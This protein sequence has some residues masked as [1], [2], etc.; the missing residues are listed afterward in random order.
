MQQQSVLAV[1]LGPEPTLLSRREVDALYETLQ[2]V[3]NALKSLRVEYIVTGGSLLGAIRQH[4]ILFCDDDIDIAIIET[5]SE[6]GT[7]TYDHVALNLQQELGSGYIYSKRPWEGGDKVRPTRMPSVFLDL[8]TIRRFDSLA[9]LIDL[10]ATKK[11]G[12]PQSVEYVQDIVSK[13]QE[14]TVTQGV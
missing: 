2:A 7:S 6:G 5:D 12:Q 11:N 14:C 9:Q 8:F 13:V 10:V 4:S 3:T 1:D